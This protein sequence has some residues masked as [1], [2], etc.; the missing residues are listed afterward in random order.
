[1]SNTPMINTVVITIG[2]SNQAGI[3]LD[4]RTWCDFK[5]AVDCELHLVG[6][7]VLQRPWV[8]VKEG[9]AYDQRGFW[10]D[11]REPAATFVALVDSNAI[12]SLKDELASVAA[13]YDQQAI[14]FI[15]VE[16]DSHLVLAQ[17]VN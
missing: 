1:M 6:C 12:L 7:T 10:K 16:G 15:A 14:G 3:Q 5:L 2:R 11:T 4:D 8:I 13:Q 17:P 9:E